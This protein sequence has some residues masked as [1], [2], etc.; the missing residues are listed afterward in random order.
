MGR[1]G[2]SWEERMGVIGEDG[3]GRW[4]GRGGW[5]GGGGVGCGGGV[6]GKSEYG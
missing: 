5:R 4:G 1:G 3:M 2:M 6:G